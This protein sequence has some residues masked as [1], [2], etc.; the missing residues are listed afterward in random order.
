MDVI[1]LRYIEKSDTEGVA[2][3]IIS[4]PEKVKTIKKVRLD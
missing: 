2:K 1:D 3:K 4:Q